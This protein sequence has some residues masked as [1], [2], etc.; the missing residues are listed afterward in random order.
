MNTRIVVD[1]DSCPVKAEIVATAAKFGVGVLMVS[2]YDHV[3]KQ[4]SGLPLFRLTAASKA[5]ICTLPTILPRKIS[6]LRRIMDLLL[7]L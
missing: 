2:S 6:S 5:R 7:W 3:I 4:V 1:G